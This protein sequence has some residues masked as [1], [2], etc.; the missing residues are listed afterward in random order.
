MTEQKQKTKIEKKKE[1][2]ST[3]PSQNTIDDDTSRKY[4]AKISI[5]AKTK[6]DQIIEERKKEDAKATLTKPIP[7][8]P[9]NFPEQKKSLDRV[10][11]KTEREAAEKALQTYLAS[12]LGKARALY[13]AAKRGDFPEVKALV[14]K[15]KRLLDCEVI[16][17]NNDLGQKV[18]IPLLGAVLGIIK[19]SQRCSK[20][21]SELLENAIDQPEW[22]RQKK[23]KNLTVELGLRSYAA[24]DS[25]KT[26]SE[27]N[28]LTPQLYYEIQQLSKE[29]STQENQRYLILDYLLKKGANPDYIASIKYRDPQTHQVCVDTSQLIDF[30]IKQIVDQDNPNHPDGLATKSLKLLKDAFE[31]AKKKQKEVKKQPNS[32]TR[33]TNM[34]N[35]SKFLVFA[36]HTSSSTSSTTST[37]SKTKED[38]NKTNPMK[39][40]GQ[41][42][43]EQENNQEVLKSSTH[44]LTPFS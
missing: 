39:P 28:Q 19:Q 24:L 5:E 6:I 21:I 34:E 31:Q 33:T 15:Q 2:K 8:T 17:E 13:Y 26:D 30:F 10:V 16:I 25:F 3:P 32:L 1:T 12:D 23:L 38:E 27:N 41:K 14:E 40:Q 37:A 4:W 18:V 20:K 36:P 42:K 22:R 44:T 9:K 35:L 29:L 11:P 7:V 43:D